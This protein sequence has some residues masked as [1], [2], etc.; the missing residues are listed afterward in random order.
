MFCGVCWGVLGGGLGGYWVLLGGPWGVLGGSWVF[1]GGPW[2]SLGGSFVLL[3]VDRTAELW[4]YPSHHIRAC[5]R[6]TAL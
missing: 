4:R 5:I 6:L 1:L 2:V 3:L